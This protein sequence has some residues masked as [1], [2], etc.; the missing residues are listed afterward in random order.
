[1]TVHQAELK[2]KAKELFTELNYEGTF[3]AS[4]GW[5]QKFLQRNR[6]TSRRVTG[7]AQKVPNNAGVMIRAFIDQCHSAIKSNGMCHTQ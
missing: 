1:M 6:F 7:H 3:K 4:R 2:N 5:I